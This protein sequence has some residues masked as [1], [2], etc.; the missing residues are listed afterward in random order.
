MRHDAMYWERNG[1]CPVC[2]KMVEDPV[3]PMTGDGHT[4]CCQCRKDIEIRRKM[5]KE[6]FKYA[7]KSSEYDLEWQKKMRKM[8][9]WACPE[10]R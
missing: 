5:I 2:H 4:L 7:R 6:G 1:I 3:N 10:G 9:P 8:F